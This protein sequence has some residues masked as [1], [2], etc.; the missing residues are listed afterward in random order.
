MNL[1]KIKSVVTDSK[2]EDRFYSLFNRVGDKPQHYLNQLEKCSEEK[3]LE[4]APVFYKLAVENDLKQTAQAIKDKYPDIYASED[5]IESDR[6]KEESIRLQEEENKRKAQEESDAKKPLNILRKNMQETK[7]SPCYGLSD[8][9]VKKYADELYE[10]LVPSSG[11]AS[12]VAGEMLRAYND[13]L[14][15]LLNDGDWIEKGDRL[16]GSSWD[17]SFSPRQV[18]NMKY[19]TSHYAPQI[20]YFINQY[21]NNQVK[22]TAATE[23]M[24]LNQIVKYDLDKKENNEDSREYWTPGRRR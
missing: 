16:F 11:P 9:Q 23:R 14:Y 22:F 20:S 13:L 4:R 19:L 18:S 6:Q 7:R 12:T 2:S 24:L 10:E 8:D 17:T 1:K 15:R 21:G 3:R 5:Q